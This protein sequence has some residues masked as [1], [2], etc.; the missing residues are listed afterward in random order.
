MTLISMNHTTQVNTEEPEMAF[1]EPWQAEAFAT[2]LQLSQNGVYSWTEWVDAFSATIRNQPQ[3][4]E[5]TAGEAYYRQWLTTL[6]TILQQKSLL[7][8][9]D[10][11]D[12]QA[13]WHLAYLHTPHGQPVQLQRVAHILDPCSLLKDMQGDDE[14]HHH[15]HGHYHGVPVPIA[16][17][18]GKG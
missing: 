12:R 10:V 4:S 8:E 1:G 9:E 16:I 15:H 14:H 18:P 17:V 6:E 5:E 11:V 13:L 3:H 7:S 2:A